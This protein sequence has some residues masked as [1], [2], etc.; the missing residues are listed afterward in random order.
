[1]RPMSN[2]KHVAILKQ[3]VDAWNSWR[4]ANPNIFPDLSK[5]NLTN[6]HLPRANLFG[7]TLIEANLTGA[8]LSRAKLNFANLIGAKLSRPTYPERT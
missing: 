3:G 7:A 6:A 5:E 2:D 4:D 1:M 8:D